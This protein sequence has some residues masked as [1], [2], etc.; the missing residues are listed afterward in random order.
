MFEWNCQKS[1]FGINMNIYEKILELKE[2]NKSFVLVTVVKSTGSTPGKPGFKMIVDREGNSYGTVGGG[3]IENEA[4]NEAGRLLAGNSGNIL[5]EYLLNKDENIVEEGLTVIPMSC[6]GKV[7]LFYEIEKNVSTIYIFGGGHVGQALTRMV[8]DL[9]YNVVVVDNRKEIIEKIGELKASKSFS[10]YKEFAETFNPD[11]DSY[12]VIVTYG[13]VHDY[14]I[15]KT[16]YKRNLVKKY[17]GVIASRNKAKE[18]IAGLKTEISSDIEHSHLH[19]PIGIKLGGDSAAEIALAIAA[20][21]QS[22]KY[23]KKIVPGGK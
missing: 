3:A 20:E 10:E 21:I 22:V 18:L 11:P 5:K 23:E 4:V 6:C 19:T 2:G 7:T 17:V 13:H 16:L 9:K 14:E 12:F 15:L 8:E 1:M